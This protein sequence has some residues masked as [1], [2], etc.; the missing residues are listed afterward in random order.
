MSS[1]RGG[2]S[3]AARVLCLEP[4]GLQVAEQVTGTLSMSPNHHPFPR[5][6]FSEE[7]NVG[8]SELRQCLEAV[9]HLGVP[10]GRRKGSDL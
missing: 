8:K 7:L 1:K 2:G 10:R 6:F 3:G 9:A 4:V 5:G